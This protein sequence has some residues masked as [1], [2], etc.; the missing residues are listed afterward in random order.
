LL[1]R[2]REKQGL[3]TRLYVQDDKIDKISASHPEEP[4][5]ICTQ[6]EKSYI[7][8]NDL[9]QPQWKRHLKHEL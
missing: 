1:L 2:S 5:D 6:Q 7:E 4:H 3:G 9:F 8:G